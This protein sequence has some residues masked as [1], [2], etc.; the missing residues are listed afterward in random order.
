M[1]IKTDF[2]SQKIFGNDLVATRKSKVILTLKKP[3]NVGMCIL[4]VLMF[5]FHCDYF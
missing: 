3:A 2:M 1:D 4:V 5:E